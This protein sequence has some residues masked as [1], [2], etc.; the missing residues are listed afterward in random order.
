[1]DDEQPRI[2]LPASLKLRHYWRL[3]HTAGKLSRLMKEFRFGPI[4]EVLAS[5]EVLTTKEVL[6]S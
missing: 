5:K 2:R 1:L 4:R 6:A 3:A